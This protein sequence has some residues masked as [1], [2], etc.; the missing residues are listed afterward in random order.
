MSEIPRLKTYI[1]SLDEKLFGGIPEKSMVLIA[2]EAGTMKST[3]SFYILYQNA[4]KANI[5]SIYITL[6]QSRE[7]LLQHI[8]SIGLDYN[9]VK[10]KISIIDLAMIRRNLEKLSDQSWIQ[11]FKMYAQNLKESNNY[12]ILVIDSLTVL[13]LLGEFKNLRNDL[14]NFFE[15]LR[16]LDSTVFILSEVHVGGSKYGTD[17]EDY[18]CDGVIHLTMENVDGINIQRRIRIVKM[19]AT[20]HSPHYYTLI[21]E[22]GKFD[23]V[24][25]ISD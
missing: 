6:E 4:L 24:R 8:G 9:L 20:N 23:L 15:W 18:V 17:G 13:E 2:G 10:D 3:L 21:F 22:N 16:T 25:A 11:I 7:S 12:K 5:N 19:R 1:D 14:F